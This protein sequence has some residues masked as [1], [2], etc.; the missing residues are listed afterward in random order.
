MSTKSRI[1]FLCLCRLPRSVDTCKQTNHVQHLMDRRESEKKWQSFTRQ[2]QI[3][4]NEHFLWRQQ[5]QQDTSCLP[6]RSV[7]HMWIQPICIPVILVKCSFLSYYQLF[8]QFNTKPWISSLYF[9]LFLIMITF[10]GLYNF[11]L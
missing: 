5:D 6:I 3:N 8:K 1:N 2:D 11:I 7:T 4:I 9:V 10:Y